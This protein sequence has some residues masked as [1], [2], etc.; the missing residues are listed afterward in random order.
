M[1]KMAT[2]GLVKKLLCDLLEVCWEYGMVP[3]V[4]RGSLTIPFP[5]RQ[6]RCTCDT[7]ADRGISPTSTVS[8]VLCIIL[9]ARLL[10]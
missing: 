1:T 4:W 8:K 5:K 9:N 2:L 6:S 3:P 10:D 7:N